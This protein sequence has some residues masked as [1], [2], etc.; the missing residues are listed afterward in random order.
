MPYVNVYEVSRAF[1][2]PEEGGWWYD[3]GNLLLFGE[4]GEHGATFAVPNR[5]TAEWLR[6]ALREAYPRTGKRSSVLGGEDY[7]VAIEDHPGRDYPEQVR[8][9]E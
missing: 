7:E 9:Y 8:R 2:G 4:S 6:D 3:T 1:G 5:E